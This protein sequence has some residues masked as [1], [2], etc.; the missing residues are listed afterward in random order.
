MSGDKALALAS[1]GGGWPWE[2]AGVP[3]PGVGR[4]WCRLCVEPKD[5]EA[6]ARWEHLARREKMGTWRV[7]FLSTGCC[8]G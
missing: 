1:H 4:G 8:V 2:W 6:G 3:G 5:L 7:V